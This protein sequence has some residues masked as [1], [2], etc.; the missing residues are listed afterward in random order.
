MASLRELLRSI[1]AADAED[2]EWLHLLVA[3]WQLLAD[4]SFSDLVLWV[5]VAD[6]SEFVAVAQLR[7]T[8]GP[9]AYQDDVVGTR[10]ARGAKPMLDNAQD[11][12]RIVRQDPQWMPEV[13]VRAEAIPVRRGDRVLGVIARTTSLVSV[14]TP[15]RLE[16]TY[17]QCAGDLARMIADGLFPQPGAVDAGD[18]S[19]RVG[20]GLIRLDAAGVVGY[21]SPNA[22]SAYRRLGLA[23]D[24]VGNHLGLLTAELVPS[25]EP[26]DEA[27]SVVASGRVAR[28]VLIE[29]DTAALRL[30]AIPLYGS[31]LADVA[32]H[33]GALVL[34]RDV[35]E[36]RRRERELITKDATIRETHH[37]VKNSLQ[38]IAALLRMQARRVDSASAREALA[39][40]ERRVGSIAIVHDTLSQSADETVDFDVVVDRVLAMVTDVSGFAAVVRPQRTGEFGR[41]PSRLAAPLSMVL[42]ELVQNALEHGVGPDSELLAVRAEREADLLCVEVVD[43]GRGLP[44]GFDPVTSAN[45]GLRIVRTLVA[46]ELRGELELGERP[47]GGTS[48]RLAIPMGRQK[49]P[50]APL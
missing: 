46:G 45:L 33:L 23:T 5:P 28:S 10:L 15:S 30:R 42:A 1:C 50:R 20:D 48:V 14:R 27:V 19:P 3:D 21:A 25:T 8:T 16:L 6:G 4:L 29:S 31:P 22:L 2:L 34:V 7:P 40:A 26:I 41:L 47:G 17:L 32:A 49:E 24:L 9:T 11:T 37:R 12:G 38:A 43:D 39:E 18:A 36:L 35:T 13:P 44:A